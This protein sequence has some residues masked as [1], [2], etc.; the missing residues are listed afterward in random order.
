MSG[1][2]LHSPLVKIVGGIVTKVLLSVV[3]LG[4]QGATWYLDVGGAVIWVE[5]GKELGVV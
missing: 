4:V 5:W 1:R 2:Y 3:R